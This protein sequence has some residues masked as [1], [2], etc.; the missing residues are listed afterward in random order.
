MFDKD[1][2]NVPIV[3]HVGIEYRSSITL[4][5]VP[6]ERYRRCMGS[7]E[8]S[9]ID[10]AKTTPLAVNRDAEFTAVNAIPDHEVIRTQA[11]TLL[12]LAAILNCSH[13]KIVWVYT[14]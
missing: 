14:F 1:M 8:R 3:G 11:Y 5:G 7:L 9:S 10:D 2:R 4:L 12:P 13:A 6:C